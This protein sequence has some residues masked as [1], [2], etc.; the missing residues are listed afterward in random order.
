MSNTT[1][2]TDQRGDPGDTGAGMSDTD[3]AAAI[4]DRAVYLREVHP[5][6]ISKQRMIGAQIQ[7]HAD[8]LARQLAEAEQARAFHAADAAMVRR[9]RDDDHRRLTAK[10]V[11]MEH[12]AARLREIADARGVLLSL[13][14]PPACVRSLPRDTTLPQWLD[15]MER[16]AKAGTDCRK[17]GDLDDG[18]QP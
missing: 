15:A 7:D 2:T 12:R 5:L 13:A 16:H 9:E 11:E 8:A 18:G 4:R 3:H 6:A 10:L 14:S 1:T 17:H